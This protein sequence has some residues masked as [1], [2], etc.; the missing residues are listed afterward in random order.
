MN[1]FKGFFNAKI[2]GTP[3]C[4]GP[5]LFILLRSTLGFAD[6]TS[7]SLP[8][9]LKCCKANTFSAGP[10]ES[11]VMKPKPLHFFVSLSYKISTFSIFPEKE[12]V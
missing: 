3:P 8:A 6:L 10:G 2:P 11:K 1:I 9:I 4:C 7:T 5:W 12:M